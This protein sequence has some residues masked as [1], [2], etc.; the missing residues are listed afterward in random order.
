MAKRKLGKD[1]HIVANKL[2]RK[3]DSAIQKYDI[4]N[5]QFNVLIFLYEQNNE[6]YQRD[7]ENYFNL[8]RSTV[9]SVIALLEKKKL[10]QKQAVKKDARLKKISLTKSGIEH[11]YLVKDTIKKENDKLISQIDPYEFEIFYKVL[12]QLSKLMD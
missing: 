12:E 5:V 1:I 11:I 8:R 6:V 3:M 9:S 4:T 2:K 7:I 10:I